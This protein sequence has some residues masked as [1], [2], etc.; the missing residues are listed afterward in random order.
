MAIGAI[1]AAAGLALSA[2][3]T[4]G[5]IFGQ[6]GAAAHQRRMNIR[7]AHQFLREGRKQMAQNRVSAAMGGTTGGGST[8]MALR[9]SE[10]NILQDYK[11]MKRGADIQYLNSAP[12]AGTYAGAA[13]SFLTSL[14]SYENDTGGISG[15]LGM[16]KKQGQNW[17]LSQ[18]PS[19]SFG[20]P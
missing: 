2:A 17:S 4:I 20:R 9:Q 14:A 19:G 1:I 15:L 7:K 6:Q 11:A 3:S 5:G 13:G 12:N 18:D 16:F 8:A 10:R